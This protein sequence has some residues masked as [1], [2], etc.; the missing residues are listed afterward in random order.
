MTKNVL[1]SLSVYADFTY[2]FS[3]PWPSSFGVQDAPGNWTGVVGEL[4]RKEKDICPSFL[5]WTIHREKVIDYTT[6]LQVD[7]ITFIAKAPSQVMRFG[8]VLQLFQPE[9]S[10]KN[11]CYQ[12]ELFINF[13]LSKCLNPREEN[14]LRSKIF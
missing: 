7:Y 10:N 5:S 4:S 13:M 9:E 2:E 8:A 12:I 3:K 6:F 14:I 11:I 1:D